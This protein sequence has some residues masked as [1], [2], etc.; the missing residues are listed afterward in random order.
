MLEREEAKRTEPNGYE[1]G[2]YDGYHKGYADKA[3]AVSAAKRQMKNEMIERMATLEIS[4]VYPFNMIYEVLDTEHPVNLCN[5]MINKVLNEKLQERERRCLEMKYRDSRTLDE[6]GK[7]YGVTRERIRQIIAKA[8]RK[9]R[10]PVNVREMQS[11]PLSEYLDLKR[12]HEILKAKYEDIVQSDGQ[13]T[14]KSTEKLGRDVLELPIEF[15]EL[16]NRSFFCL[17]RAGCNSIADVVDLIR[18]RKIVR[19]RNLGKKSI[20]EICIKLKEAGYGEDF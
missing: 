10:N 8:E 7:H 16:S 11:V 2:Y 18:T 13:E 20:E 1:R 19:V 9:L 4:N 15:L 17:R 12:E 3:S 6:I 5:E 14:E